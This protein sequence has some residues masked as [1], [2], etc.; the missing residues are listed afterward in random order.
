M[1]T[2]A[3]EAAL[4]ALAAASQRKSGG[5]PMRVAA[6]GGDATE[7]LFLDRSGWE[8]L[9]LVSGASVF[10]VGVVGWPSGN[11]EVVQLSK[12][13]YDA[14]EKALTGLRGSAGRL[15]ADGVVRTA[16]DVHFMEDNRH[17]PRFVATGAAVRQKQPAQ[18]KEPGPKVPFVTTMKAS[19]IGLLYG[20]GYQPLGLVMGSCVYHVAR[21]SLSAWGGDLRQ[22]AE[23]TGISTAFYDAREIAM[24][25]LQDEARGLGAHGVVGVTTAER[26]HVWGSRVIE[27]FAM[28]TAVAATS[29]GLLLDPP[30]LMLALNDPAP[31]TGPRAIVGEGHDEPEDGSPSSP[32]DASSGD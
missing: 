2:S 13:M 7:W 24:T 8:P 26:S 31:K 21:R 32:S 15:G 17:L 5:S 27:F 20:I 9:G 30:R 10:H 16:V 14:R 3:A 22:N 29:E 23:L 25:R 28:G 19:E 18:A 12:A 6:V 4:D 11:T 1:G